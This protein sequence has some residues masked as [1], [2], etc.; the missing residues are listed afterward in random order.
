MFIADEPL[1]NSYFGLR[2]FFSWPYL[3]LRGGVTEVDIIAFL[4]AYLLFGFLG[5]V[6]AGIL[7]ASSLPAREPA[8]A[9]DHLAPRLVPL[10]RREHRVRRLESLPCC[11]L[12]HPRDRNRQD[13]CCLVAPLLPPDSYAWLGGGGHSEGHQ[14]PRVAN[15]HSGWERSRPGPRA[16]R[17]LQGVAGRLRGR[18][19]LPDYQPLPVLSDERRQE[20]MDMATAQVEQRR[21]SVLPLS[22]TGSHTGTRFRRWLS[23][24]GSMPVVS[25]A[26][27][28]WGL[29][30]RARF[31][32]MT[33]V[34]YLSTTCWSASGYSARCK[35]PTYQNSVDMYTRVRALVT[36]SYESVA[37][38]LQ[39]LEDV[40]A[41]IKSHVDPQRLVSYSFSAVVLWWALR[42]IKHEAPSRS[43]TPLNLPHHPP[44]QCPLGAKW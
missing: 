28:R 25:S 5:L 42:E 44:L 35:P 29:R 3:H 1:V 36:E 41:V 14:A 16:S 37:D 30:S 6:A 32:A 27:V 15:A 40:Y 9:R 13:A 11:A 12:R 38:S 2:E 20:I 7:L 21:I 24:A 26:W 18:L 10:H 17:F 22:G 19:G 43:S 33:V 4:I 34:V 31:A 8:H 23:V 39:T